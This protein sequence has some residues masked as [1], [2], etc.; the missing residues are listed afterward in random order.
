[1]KVCFKK[2]LVRA[3]LSDKE[4]EVDLTQPIAEAVYQSATT[5]GQHKLAHRIAEGGGG[6]DLTDEEV[7][8]IK[9]AIS[10]FHFYAQKPI[11]EALGETFE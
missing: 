10:G 4:T 3:S 6:I 5:F 8:F 11:L 1:M 7:A 2:L 9:T